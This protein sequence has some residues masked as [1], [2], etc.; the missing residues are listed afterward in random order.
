[1]CLI[2]E[3]LLKSALPLNSRIVFVII[4][5][6]DYMYLHKHVRANTQKFTKV[7]V[8]EHLR[9]LYPLPRI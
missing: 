2:C 5:S 1:M 4:A 7:S 3:K 9:Q 6:P 8:I